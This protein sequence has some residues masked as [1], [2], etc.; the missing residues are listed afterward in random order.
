VRR[1]LTMSSPDEWTTKAATNRSRAGPVSEGDST[2]P[3]DQLLKSVR[4]SLTSAQ[5]LDFTLA[6]ARAATSAQCSMSAP[7]GV[8][9]SKSSPSSTIR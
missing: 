4:L 9:S 6:L 1:F 2:R 3:A 8:A 5:R 7:N